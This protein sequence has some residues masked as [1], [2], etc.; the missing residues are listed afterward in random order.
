M[1]KLSKRESEACRWISSAVKE[2]GG[3][4]YLVG[5]C[6]RDAL[7]GIAPKD[8]D[9]E[10][11]GLEPERIESILSR[12]FRFEVVGKSF[13]V[14]ILKGYDIDVSVPRRERKVGEGHKSFEIECDPFLPV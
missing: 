11:Y 14:W 2:A 4:A 1:I 10:I 9:M 12:R 3:R 8:V 13:G 7:L 6:V 5:G